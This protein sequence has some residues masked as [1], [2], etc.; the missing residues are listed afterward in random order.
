M[1]AEL[2]LLNLLLP[3]WN[4]STKYTKLEIH[5]ASQPRLEAPYKHDRFVSMRMF[6]IEIGEYIMRNLTYLK[7]EMR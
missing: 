2:H 5:R 3:P 7:N 1:F 6:T 4:K